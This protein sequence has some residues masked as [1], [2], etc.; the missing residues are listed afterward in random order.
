[1]IID[2]QGNLSWGNCGI[3]S[4]GHYTDFNLEKINPVVTCTRL[5]CDCG[6]DIR[7]DKEMQNAN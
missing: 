1:M 7:A 3:E 4:L 5:R 6:A 2:D